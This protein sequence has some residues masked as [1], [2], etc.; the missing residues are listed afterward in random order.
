MVETVENV[1][2]ALNLL[3]QDGRIGG[4]KAGLD[5]LV[6]IWLIEKK[7]WIMWRGGS[8]EKCKWDKVD[9]MRELFIISRCS[10][11]CLSKLVTD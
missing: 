2:R 1:I 7:D 11:R 5:E 6:E 9:E 4:G 3:E 10:R 8:E